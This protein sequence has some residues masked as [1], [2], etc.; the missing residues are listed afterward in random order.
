MSAVGF[1]ILF[2]LLLLVANGVFAMSEIA[3]VSARK[4]RLR[5]RADS[6]DA[7]ARAALELANAP[8]TFLSTVQIGITLVGIFAGAFGGATLAGQ[9]APQV[10]RVPALAPYSEA[11]SLF[12]V[13]LAIT[14]L[15]LVIGEL[16]PKRLALNNPEKV[17]AAVARPMSALSRAAAPLVRLLSLSTSA[18]LKVFGVKASAEPPVTEEEIRVLILQGAEAGVFEHSEREIVESVFRLDD[19]RVTALMTPRLEIAWLDADAPP[20]EIRRR[21][22]ESRHSRFPVARGQL[23]EVLGV[24]RTKDLLGRCLAGEPPDLRSSL[25]A[26][27]YVPESQSA[28]QLL[29][30]FRKAHTHLALVVD[31]Y[32]SVQGLVTVHDVLEAIVGDMSAARGSEPEAVERENGSWLLDGALLVDEFRE[33]FPVGELPGEGRGSYQTLAGFV[34]T[35]LGRVPRAADHFEWGG[36]R[37]EVVDMDGRRVDKVLVTPLGG[38]GGGRE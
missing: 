31:E 34:I 6:G 35:Q 23:D 13:V 1:E 12:A 8:D 18:V 37:F 26:P 24:V 30:L 22:A 32:G 29:E 10:A 5:Q 2:V 17:A 3:L 27:L 20:E 16:A 36:L 11:V 9:L 7:R 33:I 21:V 14:Y 28:L 15:S 4:A 25:R 19:R 38:D